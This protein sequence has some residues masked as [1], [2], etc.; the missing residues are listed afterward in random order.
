M[1]ISNQAVPPALSGVLIYLKKNAPRNQIS[2][3]KWQKISTNDRDWGFLIES[4]KTV[5][6]NL[7]HGGKHQDGML[8][9]PARDG[10]LIEFCLLIMKELIII[11]PEE[12]KDIFDQ[13]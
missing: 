4:L 6:N 2:A 3:T 11:L 13:A 12:V 7:F 8:L 10:K 1:R 5:R 9:E